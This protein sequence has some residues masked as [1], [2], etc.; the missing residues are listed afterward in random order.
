MKKLF[1]VIA[2]LFILSSCN[3][4]NLETKI[5]TK[6]ETLI[7][8]SISPISSIVN[9]ISDS[10]IKTNTIVPIWV[11][12]H[13]FDM[14]VQEA[15]NISDSKIVFTIWSWLDSFLDS[16]LEGKYSVV[17]SDFV[18]LKKQKVH[19][20]D[21]H[22]NEN[23]EHA[24]EEHE[25]NEL[26]NDPHIWLW[27]ENTSII[28]EKV[29]EELTKLDFSKK[30]F[31]KSNL[32]SFNSELTKLTNDFEKFSKNKKTKNFIVFH[33]AYNYLFDDL[34]IDQTKKSIFEETPGEEPSTAE[35]KELVDLIKK[36]NIKIIFKE[37]ELSSKIVDVLEKDYWL[38]VL[39]LSPLGKSDKKW[40]Y[41][42]NLKQNLEVLK[43]IYE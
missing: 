15:R 37:P 35:F 31:Y 11:T 36:N 28:A 3:N 41:L 7:T 1:L 19:H 34:K 4:S 22:E 21:E 24:D 33:D 20:H 27:I 6:K 42:E 9:E 2:L 39:E 25:E 32:N 16:S 5:D 18:Q 14:K 29:Y 26:V 43:N 12:P 23:D 13:W 8:S 38:K 10:S 40:A 30:D 17:L